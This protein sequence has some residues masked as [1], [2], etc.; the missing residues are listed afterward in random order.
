MGFL[1]SANSYGVPIDTKGLK[2][3]GADFD[4]ASYYED[5]KTYIGVVDNW[6]RLNREY[7]DLIVC[8]ECKQL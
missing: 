2:R 8:I 3:T 4:T 7:K 5:N 1:S 6:I